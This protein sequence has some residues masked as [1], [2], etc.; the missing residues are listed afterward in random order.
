MR[1]VNVVLEGVEAIET[2][3]PQQSIAQ[4]AQGKI[5]ATGSPSPTSFTPGNA[6]SDRSVHDPIQPGLYPA[7]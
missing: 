5:T 6:I 4:L 3:L 2:V 7:S 1:A